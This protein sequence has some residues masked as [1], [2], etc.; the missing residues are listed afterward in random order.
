[1]DL[2]LISLADHTQAVGESATFKFSATM[3][4]ATFGFINN[5]A[6]TVPEPTTGLLL[7]G[8]LAGLVTL[9]RRRQS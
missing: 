2:S 9:H 1:M 7:I 8:A 5:V 4:T 6:V 3:T